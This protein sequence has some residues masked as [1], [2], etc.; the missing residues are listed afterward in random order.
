VW[1][2]TDPLEIQNQGKFENYFCGP[3]YGAFLGGAF[4]W[5]E[6]ETFADLGAPQGNGSAIARNVIIDDYCC[7]ARSVF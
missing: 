5:N 2:I 4:P 7:E 3:I 6:Y 1:A